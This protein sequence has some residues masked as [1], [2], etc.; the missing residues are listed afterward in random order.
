MRTNTTMKLTA[1]AAAIGLLVSS[2]VFATELDSGTDSLTLGIDAVD[3]IKIT[4]GSVTLTIDQATSDGGTVLLPETSSASSWAVTTNS[5]ST[6]TRKIYAS[7]P[8]KMPAGATLAIEFGEASSVE[9]AAGGI[10]EP[11]EGVTFT[12]ADADAAVKKVYDG[13]YQIVTSS[14]SITYTF[15]ATVEAPIG[16]A[17]RVVTY[18]LTD[19]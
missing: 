15:S 1:L 7:I 12:S 14:P 2:G 4:S 13:L 6:A 11:V 8:T 18:T 17:S 9:G 16:D 10:G 3:E 19:S 5:P